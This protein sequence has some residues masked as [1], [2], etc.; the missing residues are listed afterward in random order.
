MGPMFKPIH[1]IGLV[2]LLLAGCGGGKQPGVY[3]IPLAEAYSRLEKA[4]INGFRSARQCGILVHLRPQ[5][6]QGEAITWYVTSSGTEVFRFTVKLSAEGEG[7]RTEIE[8]PAD[9]KGGEMYDG[10]QQYARPA[11]NQPIRPAIRELIDAAMENRPYDVMR[12]PQ[13]RNTDKVCSIQRSGLESGSF[14]FGVDDKAG[15]D[16]RASARAADAEAAEDAAATDFDNSYGEPE[17]DSGSW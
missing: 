9:P 11:F 7:T 8:V 1:S 17:G 10:K 3:E 5:K 15:M 6:K 13:P 12:I 2:L 16:A 4:D 14:V